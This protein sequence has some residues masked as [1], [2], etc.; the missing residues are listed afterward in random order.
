MNLKKFKN[1]ISRLFLIAALLFTLNPTLSTPLYGSS[2]A[3]SVT[4]SDETPVVAELLHEETS[5][6]PGR[7]FLVAIHLKIEKN[8]HCYWKNPGDVGF[9]VSIDWLLPEGFHASAI[10][11]PVPKRFEH[12]EITGYGFENE[13]ILLSEITPPSTLPENSHVPLAAELKW[14]A[15]SDNACLPGSAD[16]EIHLPTQNKLP[17]MNPSHRA[18]FA[19]AKTKLPQD[20]ESDI[21][22]S[23]KSDL[24]EIVLEAP[25]K[26]KNVTKALFFPDEQNHIDPKISA[27]LTPHKE[28]PGVYIVSLKEANESDTKLEHLR[29]VLVLQ[30]DDHNEFVNALAI[31]LPITDA[32]GA[33]HTSPFSANEIAQ[34]TPSVLNPISIGPATSAK[35]GEEGLLFFILT[36]FVGG[37]ILNLMPCVLPVVSFKIMSFVK[38]AGQDRSKTFKHGLAFSLGVLVSF[39]VLAGVLLLL[40]AYGQSVGWGFQLQEPIFVA[41]LAA[42][43][44]IFSL[45]MFGVFELGTFLASMAGQSQAEAQKNSESFYSSFFSG[46]L[47]TAVATP[48]TGPFLGPAVGFAVTQ[49]AFAA[50]AIFTSLG[51]GMAAPYL[52]LS[53]FPSLMRFMPK[54]GNWMIT[55]REITGFF[56][57][58]TTFWLLWV[59]EA[60]TDS[61]ALFL[62]L[63]AL[64]VF[65]V[66]AWV[67]GKWTTPIRA[68]MIRRIGLASTLIL[69]AVGCKLTYSAVYE[70]HP[71]TPAHASNTHPSSQDLIAL[72]EKGHTEKSKDSNEWEAFSPERL[73]QLQEEGIPVFIDFTARWCLIC[74]TNHAT[75]TTAEVEKNFNQKGVVKMKADWTKRDPIITQELKKHG[76]N[77]VPLY[78]LYTGDANAEPLI[79]PQLLTPANLAEHL[80]QLPNAVS[81]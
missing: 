3:T 77:S 30:D 51:I 16:V 78:V 12:D 81:K 34:N 79:L 9:P 8:W 43:I 26:F 6:Q 4:T 37:M 67:Y 13:V 29:G 48:C 21:S 23:R 59:F 31:N 50:L 75:L 66:G 22:A 20:H 53:A 5:I 54:P 36:A 38:M 1:S 56:L 80:D 47:A 35:Q 19:N 52:L 71:N 15:C 25:S 14:L 60:L 57:L 58:G 69:F 41:L 73:K 63:G 11:W 45:S 18:L 62:F 32:V 49:P 65:A 28:K 42:I 24:L 7:P 70:T 44:F 40:Q 46:V 33:G 68:K 55:F 17:S 76:R 10:Q 2:K 61:H 74:Q 64:L 72:N 39:W 27:T